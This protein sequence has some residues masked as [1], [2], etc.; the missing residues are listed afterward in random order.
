MIP[1][2]A[3]DAVREDTLGQPRIQDAISRP[4]PSSIRACASAAHRIGQRDVHRRHGASSGADQGKDCRC[5]QSAGRQTAFLHPC[6]AP[7]VIAVLSDRPTSFLPAA[8]HLRGAWPFVPF[9]NIRA[10]PPPGQRLVIAGSV[11]TSTPRRTA[12]S[13]PKTVAGQTVTAPADPMAR[14]RTG[15]APWQLRQLPRP[16]PAP[17]GRHV[18]MSTCRSVNRLFRSFCNDVNGLTGQGVALHACPVPI[19]RRIATG[20]LAVI[21]TVLV[22]MVAPGSCCRAH[23]PR[24]STDRAGA[25]AVATGATPPRLRVHHSSFRRT[26]DAVSRY[27]RPIPR[28]GFRHI[29]AARR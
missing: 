2:A 18:H 16:I 3:D 28:P 11:P 12:P 7:I 21:L 20:L 25:G 9:V 14:G 23:H 10:I 17:T 26:R 29:C 8:P 6:P 15:P 1:T 13:L 4:R 22:M 5:S 24:R 19:G 27:A